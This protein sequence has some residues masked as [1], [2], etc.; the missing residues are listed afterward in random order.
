MP[1]ITIHDGDERGCLAFDLRDLLRLAGDVARE[2]TWACR[3]VE[4]ISLDSVGEDAQLHDAFNSGGAL[5]GA[6]LLGLADQTLQVIDGTFVASHPQHSSS[7]LRLEAIDSSYWE[8]EAP[9]PAH[10][11]PFRERFRDVRPSRGSA[12]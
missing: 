1:A 11:V 8:V 7:W 10:L 3:V 9:S 4:C 6:E 2:S 5:S 12:A